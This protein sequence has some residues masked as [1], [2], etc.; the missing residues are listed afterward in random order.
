MDLSSVAG[1]MMKRCCEGGAYQFCF[2][3][4]VIELC[5]SVWA[6]ETSQWLFFLFLGQI[7]HGT[8]Q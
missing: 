1:P 7:W 2:V 6:R 3:G 4:A 5:D 8:A